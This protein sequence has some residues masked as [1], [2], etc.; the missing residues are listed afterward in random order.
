MQLS[1]W[2]PFSTVSNFLWSTLFFTKHV[3]A[4]SVSILTDHGSSERPT[5]TAFPTTCLAVSEHD[6][7]G[8]LEIWG[9][10]QSVP[11][12]ITRLWT[13]SEGNCIRMSTSGAI[14]PEVMT[15]SSVLMTSV[16][17]W[18]LRME[19]R[20]SQTKSPWISRILAMKL[21]PAVRNGL[22]NSSVFLSS[23]WLILDSE[24]P[25]YKKC[26]EEYMAIH[27]EIEEKKNASG[28]SLILGY[29]YPSCDLDG[30]YKA[31]QENK[32]Q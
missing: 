32:T 24:G 19:P 31:I 18:T 25:Y 29:S 8:N 11:E 27:R 26:E 30:S 12:L 21:C 13:Y 6:P 3:S 7:K 2:A 17:V 15:K 5:T 9:H 23:F 28:Y 4:A 22:W 14:P 10:F 16:Y 1:I 20:L